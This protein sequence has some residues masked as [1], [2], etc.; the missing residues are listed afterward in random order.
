MVERPIVRAY[1]S[2]LLYQ[3]KDYPCDGRL[4]VDLIGVIDSSAIIAAPVRSSP[5]L[6][7][8]VTWT[9]CDRNRTSCRH[10]KREDD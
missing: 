8:V 10:V 6:I 5:P 1:E 3:H 4:V 2:Y 7:G 9:N